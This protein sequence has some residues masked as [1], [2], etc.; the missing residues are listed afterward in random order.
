MSTKKQ[1]DMNQISEQTLRQTVPAIFTTNPSPKMSNRYTFVPTLEIL[2][3]F[4]KE[5]WEVSSARQTGQSQYATHEVRLRNG[6]MPKVGDSIFET[7]IRN[8]HNGMTT[9]SVSSGLHRLV[10]SNGL[11]IPTSLAEQFNI[12]HTSFDL[13]E[14]RR[15]TDIFAERLPMIQE[16]M[17]K[18]GNRILTEDEKVGFVK[19]AASIRWKEGKMPTAISVDSILIPN[20]EE[21][22][23]DDLW[24]VFNVVQEKFVRGGVEYRATG[25]RMT[26]M[27]NLKNIQAINKINTEL[28]ELADSYC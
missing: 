22:M 10:C 1:K 25:G 6:G 18:M 27:R 13:G 20:R 2:E 28:W 17:G 11:T 9:F 3:N 16:S 12:R 24:K 19:S 23:G 5:G 26:G 21:D 15:L 8:S 7:I 4:Q 14:V